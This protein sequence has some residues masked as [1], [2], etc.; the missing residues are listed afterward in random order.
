MKLK[1]G[2]TVVLKL[3][4]EYKYNRYSA[5][6]RKEIVH[7]CVAQCTEGDYDVTLVKN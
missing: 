6:L 1:S 3:K 4:Q 7:I 2:G 5:M